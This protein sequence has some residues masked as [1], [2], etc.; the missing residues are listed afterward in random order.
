MTKQQEIINNQRYIP[1]HN[2][3][4]VGLIDFM[5]ND[6]AIVEAAKTSYGKGTKAVSDDRTL[7]RYLMRHHHDTPT[8]M[9]DL[10]FHLKL[11]I[12]VMRQL[13]RHRTSSMSEASLRYSEAT[14]EFY[15]PENSYLAPQSLTN[16][17]GRSGTLSDSLK[18]FIKAVM[19]EY[20]EKAFEIYNKLISSDMEGGLSRELSRIILPVSTYTECYWKCNLRNFFHFLQLRMDH[21]AQQ[22]IRDYANAMYELIKPHFPIS[23]EAFE[24]YMYQSK[25]LSRMDVLAIRDL[26]AGNFKNDANY[27]GMGKREWTEFIDFWRINS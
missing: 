19:T 7:I 8:E 22:E 6:R 14:D 12:F 11:P 3:G 26:L 25:N 23:C 18:S 21:H 10:K 16:K 4:F 5:G 2:H 13:Q 1:I 15:I 24:D 9:A 20:S 27:Y 17:Q